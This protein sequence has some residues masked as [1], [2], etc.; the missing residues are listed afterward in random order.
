MSLSRPLVS[1]LTPSFNQGK[2][3]RDTLDSVL[4]QDYPHIEHIVVDG[5]STD[6]TAAVVSHYDVQFVS[7][8][9]EGQ[10]DALNK[11]FERASGSIVGWL[12]SDD[13]FLWTGAVSAAVEAFENAGRDVDVV[14]GHSVWVDERNRVVKTH[15]RP[16]FSARRLERFGYLSQPATFFRREDV[17][18]PLVDATL[19]Y[20]LDYRLWLRFL[21]EGKR[22]L[23]LDDY[24]AAM[25][26]HP[27]AKSVFARAHQWEEDAE[28]RET[29][30]TEH[31]GATATLLDV[32]VMAGMKFR[33][34]TE[35]RRGRLHGS[36]WCVP[37]T[38]PNVL[39]RPLF[40]A[41]IVGSPGSA[42]L[43]VRYL[44][45]TRGRTSQGTA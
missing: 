5:S 22:F 43:L 28:V 17:E 24:V 26:Y 4:V 31:R 30:T 9:D 18:S 2:F 29:V 36:E 10:G 23:R 44:L 11:A 3:I 13:F 6:D 37:L 41:G 35:Y 16:R 12:N 19:S 25:R 20:T 34:L 32:G 42:L 45:A 33:G 21:H 15:P 14:Y 8:P 40:Q 7:E 38:L 39:A 1:I 27:A